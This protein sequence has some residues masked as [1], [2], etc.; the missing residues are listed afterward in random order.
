MISTWSAKLKAL[1]KLSQFTMLELQSAMPYFYILLRNRIV[2]NLFFAFS[3]KNLAF[4]LKIFAF[5]QE[6][7]VLKRNAKSKVNLPLLNANLDAGVELIARTY[8]KVPW[9]AIMLMC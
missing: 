8:F 4:R 7:Q 9:D 6:V 2:A 1:L 3:L 5:G